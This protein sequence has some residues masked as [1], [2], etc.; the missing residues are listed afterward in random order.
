[1]IAR[2]HLDDG[3]AIEILP[4]FGD[5]ARLGIGPAGDAWGYN[6]VW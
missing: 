4:L 1:V 3:R 2:R 5:R 6:A